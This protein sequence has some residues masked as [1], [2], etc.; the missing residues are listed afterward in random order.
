MWFGTEGGLAKFDG[1][2]TQAI[3][4]PELPAGRVLALQTDLDG[5]LWIG[6]GSG[7]AR[8]A[9]GKFKQIREL[10]GKAVN[11]II[12]PERSHAILATEQGMIYDCHLDLVASAPSNEGAVQREPANPNVITKSLLNQPLQSTDVDRPGLLPLTSL[13][14]ANNKLLVGSSSRGVLEVENGAARPLEMRPQAYFVRAL[15]VDAQGHLWL[16]TKG[17]KEESG[18]YE[19]GDTSRITRVDLPTGTVTSLRDGGNGD[20]WVGS[21]GRGVFQFKGPKEFV[22]FTF[23]GTLGGLRSDHVYAIFV[24]REAV[25]WFGTDRGVSRYDPN[26]PRVEVV[27]DNPESNFVRTLFQTSAGNLFCGTNRGLFVFDQKTRSWQAVAEL[28]RSIIYS[29]AEDKNGKLLVGSASGFYVGQSSGRGASNPNQFF[30]HVESASG[31]VDAPGSVRAIAQFRGATY[32]ATFGRGVERI[33]EGRARRVWQGNGNEAPEAISLSADDDQRLFIGTTKGVVV[34]DGQAAK[35]EP[36][37]DLFKDATVR[38]VAHGTDGSVWFATSRG[39]FACGNDGRCVAAAPNFDARSVVVNR[40]GNAREAWCATTG[41]GMIKILLDDLHG[42]IVSQLDAEQGLP[43]QNV[44]AVWPQQ[45]DKGNAELLIGTSRGVVSYKPGTTQPA[46]SPTRIISKRVHPPEELRTGLNLEYPQNSLLLDVTA[47]S[48]RTFPEQFQYAFVLTDNNGKL[49]KQK[50]SRDSQFTMEGLKPGRY[51]ATASAFTKDLVSSAPLQFEFTV[52]GAPF[53]W[54]STALAVLLLLAILALIWAIFEHRN[55]VRTSAALVEANTE[56]A[57]ARLDLANEAERERRRIAR[58]LHD[59]TLADLRRLLLITDSMPASSARVTGAAQAAA[60]G[61]GSNGSFEPAMFRKEIESVSNEI[62]RICED[63]SPS[64]LDNV[65]LAAA[66]EWALAN[67][68]AHLPAEKKFEYE[69][70]SGE[71]IEDQIKIEPGERIQIY[72]IAQEVINNICRH[73]NARRVRLA[74]ESVDSSNLK[75]TIEDDGDFF[76]PSANHPHGRGLSN[77]H[78]RASLLEAE[79]SWQKRDPGGTVFSLMKGPS[80]ALARP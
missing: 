4:D 28:S 16:G 57:G 79:V 7:A 74:L 67:A 15:E 35:S 49:I 36:Q 52:A 75:L 8:L 25:V 58:D 23:D 37:F 20:M 39:V 38:S 54:T 53:P 59:Q 47:I 46:L 70:S 77:I 6:T 78:A 24:D 43:S 33:E 22:R 34:F 17:R 41:G 40:K 66:L 27:G 48:S 63:L 42:P 14:L 69:I 55:I 45:D 80:R 62:R 9:D 18:Y 64:V 73:S 1:R 21:D 60:E 71:G 56:L 5:S 26:A 68:V 31:A 44:F 32:I 11:A 50:L 72:R 51:K 65:G 3:S 61:S 10:N 19:G 2:R 76:A 13:K 29:L 30:A 12:A